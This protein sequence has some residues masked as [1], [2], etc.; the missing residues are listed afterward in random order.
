M[1]V[2]VWPW[3]RE[4]E[5][6]LLFEF[7]SVR[8]GR[9]SRPDY[10]HLSPTTAEKTTARKASRLP[11]WS[12][13]WILLLCRQII[14]Q[15]I[16]GS[17]L[18]ILSTAEIKFPSSATGEIIP[19]CNTAKLHLPEKEDLIL[20]TCVLFAGQYIL[21]GRRVMVA[22]NMS[23]GQSVSLFGLLFSLVLTLAITLQDPCVLLQW[24][25]DLWGFFHH[26]T[27]KQGYETAVKKVMLV[28]SPSCYS[29]W[30]VT[31]EDTRV[32]VC[33]RDWE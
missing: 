23:L 8:L 7:A 28:T 30:P 20:F 16:G 31:S 9:G 3:D 19:T 24:S 1:C 17:L 33:L 22:I 13:S 15:L 6:T 2:C 27:R 26:S 29:T 4:R 18:S 14:S 21:P 32:H 12:R 10:T 11:L 5:K 25:S